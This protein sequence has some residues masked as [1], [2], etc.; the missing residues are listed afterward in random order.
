M[1]NRTLQNAVFPGYC[2]L[3][4]CDIQN[5]LPSRYTSRYGKS[6]AIHE[7][8]HDTHTYIYIYIE[9]ERERQRE[10]ERERPDG[11]FKLTRV[12]NSALNKIQL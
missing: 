12:T 1:G 7:S 3:R 4:L 5:F 9:R 2:V 11:T 6:I 8:I 10:R